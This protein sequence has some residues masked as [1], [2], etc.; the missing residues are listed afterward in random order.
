MSAENVEI[1]KR[2]IAALNA[3]DVEGALGVYA[4]D[5]ELRDLQSAPDQPLEVNGIEAIRGIWVSWAAAFDELR[6]DVDEFTAIG[7]SVVASAH[8]QGEGKG[9]GLSIDNHQFDLSEFE[10]GKIIRVVLGYRSKADA[11][12]AVQ[13]QK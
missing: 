12:D 4:K 10:G 3:G 5:A 7:D 8:W 13:A 2:A 1:L 11:I 9:S 6:V